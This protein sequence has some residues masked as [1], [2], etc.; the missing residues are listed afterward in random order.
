MESLLTVKDVARMLSVPD[1]TVYLWVSQRKLPH[2]KI[3][4]TV[5][6]YPAEI[7]EWIR[8][9][10]VEASPSAQN[11]GAIRRLRTAKPLSKII[12]QRG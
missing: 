11:P 10:R 12:P 6:F 2:Y 8:N 1:Q 9:R 4:K 5:R 3:G 7:E